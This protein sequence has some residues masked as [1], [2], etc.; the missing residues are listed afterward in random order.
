ML[1]FCAAAVVLSLAITACAPESDPD[2]DEVI[3]PEEDDGKADAETELRVRVADTTIWLARGLTR[4]GDDYVLRGRT[5]RT[6]TEGFA[7]IFDDPYGDYAMRGPRSFEVRWGVSSIRGLMDGVNQFL[8]LGF[9]P[10]G[11]RVGFVTARLI[12]RPRLSSIS[13]AGAIYLTAEL[14]PV[15][16]AGRVVYRVKGKTTGA[17]G[18]VTATDAG[19]AAIVAHVVD[20]THF[21]LDLD[22]AQVVAGKVTVAVRSATGTAWTKT[23][24][25]GLALKV[26]GATT[27]DIEVVYPPVQC[28]DQTLACLDG[29][30]DGALDTA[31]CGDARTVNACRGRLGV[32]VDA[33]ARDAAHAAAK[34]RLEDPA[35]FRTDAVGLVGA[36]RAAALVDFTLGD[37]DVA[38]DAI[39]GRWLLDETARR[40]VVDGAVEGAIDAAY[41]L[42]LTHFAPRAPMPGDAAVTRQLVAD[43]VL[44]HLAAQDYVHSA[45]GRSLTTLARELRARHVTSIRT[46]REDAV[47]E[48]HYANAAWDLYTGRWLDAYTEVSVDRVAGTV[49][50]VLVELD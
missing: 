33:A 42:P 32:V 22:D 12:V 13:G 29:L 20:A 24:N 49:A 37:V 4:D 26:F 18:E 36:D 7:F 40:T 25:V 39:S 1:R 3:A 50:G 11:D 35:G 6:L 9:A 5:S 17:F 16:V 44:L 27:E 43:G 45:F 47:A 48:P 14:T 8:R 10:S 34:T 15:V 2:T 21:T 30:A 31:T 46:F 19:G 28:A 23:A 41:A 38:L